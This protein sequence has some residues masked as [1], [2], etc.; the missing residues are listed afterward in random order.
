MSIFIIKHKLVNTLSYITILLQN[1]YQHSFY[2]LIKVV[3]MA[4]SDDAR[5][6]NGTPEGYSSLIDQNNNASETE[7]SRSEPHLVI[8]GRNTGA[9]KSQLIA[10]VL[11]SLFFFLTSSFYSIF[12]PF[13]P[14]VATQKGMSETQ[15]GVIFGS[16]QF[17]L[18]VLSPIFGKYV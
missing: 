4:P 14:G 18:L 8:C 6:Q 13:Y 11:L 9:T 1:N 16:F 5:K 7:S 12:A 10:I 17:V 2:Y 15:I 3:K